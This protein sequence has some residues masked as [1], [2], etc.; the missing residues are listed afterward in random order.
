M[1]ALM[2]YLAFCVN[3]ETLHASSRI[4]S[5]STRTSLNHS[6]KIFAFSFMFHENSPQITSSSLLIH[7]FFLCRSKANQKSLI[8]RLRRLMCSR[9][10]AIFVLSWNL[11]SEAS[12]RKNYIRTWVLYTLRAV[13]FFS[14]ARNIQPQL[15]CGRPTDTDDDDV[16][17]WFFS[18]FFSVRVSNL[19]LAYFPTL[20]MS[21]NPQGFAGFPQIK[22]KAHYEK[23]MQSACGII[24]HQK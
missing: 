19:S 22:G 12:M 13:L 18:S 2:Y 14:A 20:L 16:V 10:Y 1:H 3:K 11:L 6:I 7:S 9:V 23:F 4:S 21:R 8:S 17:Y 24:I 15:P 5:L